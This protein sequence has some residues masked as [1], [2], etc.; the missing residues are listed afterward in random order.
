M[1]Y[2][3]L[4]LVLNI[5]LVVFPQK[6]SKEERQAILENRK[7]NKGSYETESGY[8]FAEGDTIDIK[9]K[10]SYNYILKGRGLSI[11]QID[12][13]LSQTK[14]VI[15]NIK[16]SLGVMIAN[17]KAS[18]GY[19]SIM[20]DA[21]S[22]NDEIRFSEEQKQNAYQKQLE[23][24]ISPNNYDG[25]SFQTLNWNS[26]KSDIKSLFPDIK[27][28]DDIFTVDTNLGT[29]QTNLFFKFEEN[30]LSVIGYSFDNKHSNDNLYIDD[31]KEIKS[32]LVEKYGT[33]TLDEMVWSDNLYKSDY[34]RYGFAISLGHLEYYCKWELPDVDIVL[35]LTGDNYKISHLLGYMRFPRLNKSTSKTEM[36]KKL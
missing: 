32:L 33:P 28:S 34:S 26:S 29:Y 11:T 13:K 35:K 17:C 9:S 10:S 1:K 25:F 20:L 15:K 2:L 8:T 23:S 3:I 31:Y 30:E 22:L 21:A 4:F 7:Q 19:Y 24:R 36:L 18:D 14:C 27:I 16:N 12:H 6:L 5:P